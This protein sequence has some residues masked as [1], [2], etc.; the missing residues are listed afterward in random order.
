[1][2]GVGG[3]IH[4]V[5]PD[6]YTLT[7]K[8]YT[9]Q[10]Y[11]QFLRTQQYNFNSLSMDQFEQFVHD[12]CK[13]L[14][15]DIFPMPNGSID[16]WVEILQLINASLLTLPARKLSNWFPI[17]CQC[18]LS[19]D[20]ENEQDKQCKQW[21]RQV[22]KKLRLTKMLNNYAKPLSTSTSTSTPCPYSQYEYTTLT[23]TMPVTSCGRDGCRWLNLLTFLLF[24]KI[25][26]L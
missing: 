15:E 10:Y 22:C 23:S 16:D 6:S 7:M 3:D 26:I 13:I 2:C 20:K 25:L 8:I 24:T 21:R 14:K 17:G 18:C 12:L 19:I 5:D 4:I 1:M 11:L 9:S